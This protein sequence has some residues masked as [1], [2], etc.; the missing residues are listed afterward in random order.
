LKHSHQVALLQ[1]GDNTLLENPPRRGHASLTVT[2]IV[3]LTIVL[4]TETR[5]VPLATTQTREHETIITV[6]TDGMTLGTTSL[7]TGEIMTATAPATVTVLAK[8]AALTV[9]ATAIMTAAVT[10]KDE[11]MTAD[12]ISVTTMI[13]TVVAIAHHVD[14]PEAVGETTD[15][16]HPGVVQVSIIS[17]TC[18]QLIR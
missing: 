4:A 7:I 5:A 6:M 15:H 2:L 3:P 10:V 14:V 18:A 13:V 11:I 1:I 9:T 12:A 17:G 16:G 8:D